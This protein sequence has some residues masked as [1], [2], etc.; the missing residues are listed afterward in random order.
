M[1]RGGPIEDE[2]LIPAGRGD[3]GVGRGGDGAGIAGTGEGGEEGAGTHAVAVGAGLGAHHGDAHGGGRALEEVDGDGDGLGVGPVG[4]GDGEGRLGVAG[5]EVGRDEDL[6]AVLLRVDAVLGVG[7]GDHDAAVAHED[8]FGVVE[9]RDGGVGHDA[10]AGV[11]RF[12][13]VVQHRVEVGRGGEPEAG[14]A[15]VGAVEDEEGAIRQGRHARDD[16]LR[17]HALDR[18]VLARHFGL[19][20]DAVVDGD[21]GAGGGAAADED[22]ERRGVRRHERQEHGRAFERVRAPAE[23]VV[24]GAGHVGE[25]AR[26]LEG[27]FVED[28]GLVEVEDEDAARGEDGEEGVEVVRVRALEPVAVDGRVAASRGREDLER[29]HG[30]AVRADLPAHDEDRSVGHDHRARVPSS[31]LEGQLVDVFLPIVRAGHT[32]RAVG[33]VQTDAERRLF[34]PSSD[35]DLPSRF[36]GQGQTGGAEDV[37][38]DMHRSPR[39]REVAGDQGHIQFVRTGRVGL[40]GPEFLQEGVLAVDT[41]SRQERNADTPDQLLVFTSQRTG[42]LAPSVKRSAGPGVVGQKAAGPAIS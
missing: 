35:I 2:K 11:D 12:G 9:A 15:L 39:P 19:D 1:A 6:D 40:A 31:D 37:G 38:L 4:V 14:D 26:G 29:G 24:D 34:G 20:G 33:P 42:W 21:A 7:A 22:G 28:A 23:K 32:G 5:E 25:L 16:A 8:G 17:R 13:G 27:D 3:V 36:V 10:H 41:R 30:G 18:P